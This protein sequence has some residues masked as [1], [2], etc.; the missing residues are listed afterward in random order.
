MKRSTWSPREFRL[1]LWTAAVIG[2]WVVVSWWL[3]PLWDRAH[4]LGAAALHARQRLE[5]LQQLLQ[6]EPAI[7]QRYQ[8]YAAY[9]SAQSQELL[10]QG[11]LD[12]LEEWARTDNVQMNLKPR[13]ASRDGDVARLGVEVEVEATQEALLAFL[14]R[15]LSQPALIE[16]ERLK[17]T[18]TAAKERP[19]R[20]SLV[21]SQVAVRP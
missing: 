17:I 13:P 4:Q 11:L 12:A 18:V 14:G 2:L 1:A 9:Q 8:A 10:R 3:L 6:R 19:L 5:H 7:T 21:L 20:A 16:L 15:V